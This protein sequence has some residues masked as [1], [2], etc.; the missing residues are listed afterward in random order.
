MKKTRILE[1]FVII[2]IISSLGKS[3]FLII[4]NFADKKINNLSTE[5]VMRGHYFHEILGTFDEKLPLLL[6]ST[7]LF[8]YFV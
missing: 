4:I 2:I 5:L 8:C 1:A 3:S 6:L 7:I